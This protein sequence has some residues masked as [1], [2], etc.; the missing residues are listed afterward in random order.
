MIIKTNNN[1]HNN[2]LKHNLKQETQDGGQ[3]KIKII[4]INLKIIWIV[5]SVKINRININMPRKCWRIL[6]SAAK[7]HIKVKDRN[8]KKV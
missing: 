2:Y 1:N 3:I 6:I 8:L 4:Q 7:L 5:L